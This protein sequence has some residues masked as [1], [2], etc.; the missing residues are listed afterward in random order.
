M[1]TTL[2][3]GTATTCLLDSAEVIQLRPDEQPSLPADTIATTVRSSLREPLNFPP[4]S[5]ATI[6]GDRVA[7]AIAPRIP[8]QLAVIDG[9]L[10]ALKDAGTEQSLVVIV[11]ADPQADADALTAGLGAL[12]HTECSVVNHDP[13]NEKEIAMLG[14][15]RDG[16]AIRMNRQLFDAD[17]VLPIFATSCEPE[18]EVLAENYAGLFPNFS[19]RETIERVTT[20][21]VEQANTQ[22]AGGLTE[23]EECGRLLGVGMTM[24]VVP[25]SNGQALAICAGDPLSVTKQATKKYRDTW[26]SNTPIRGQLIIAT[27]TGAADQQTWNNVGR[28]IAAAGAVVEEGGAIVICSELEEPP[29][30]ALGHLAGNE[31]YQVVEREILRT[32]SANSNAAIQLCRA[33]ERGPI[34]LR[35]RLRSSVVESLSITPLESDHEIENLAQ[36]HRPC[37]VLAEAQHLLPRVTEGE[38]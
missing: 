25:S 7:L 26:E 31:D 12:G 5:Q 28:A 33:L 14:V 4:L 22:T 18:S 13:G 32:P 21:A 35:S 16:Q 24:Q 3:Y 6:P 2:T 20:V 10:Q 8:Q 19:D 11:L 30:H 34:F 37:L 36:A 1:A 17:V 9:A 15:T 29:G 27:I 38:A 23:T